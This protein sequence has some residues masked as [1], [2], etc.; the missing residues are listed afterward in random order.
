MQLIDLDA[1]P[2]NQNHLLLMNIECLPLMLK[3]H[4]HLTELDML[5]LDRLANLKLSKLKPSH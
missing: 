5:L 1:D 2:R 3:T 4:L